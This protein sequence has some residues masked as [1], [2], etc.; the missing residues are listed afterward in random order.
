MREYRKK[1]YTIA[2]M[3]GD[4]ESDYSGELLKGFIPVR[5]KRM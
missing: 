1:R 5:R 3:L 2:I 4:M